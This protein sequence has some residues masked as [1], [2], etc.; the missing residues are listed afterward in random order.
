MSG[1]ADSDA[2]EGMELARLVGMTSD[3]LPT[4]STG[5]GPTAP[6]VSDA[7]RQRIRRKKAVD[8]AR[9]SVRFEGFIWPEEAEVLFARYV[10]GELDSEELTTT[11]L[12]RFKGSD[13]AD[14]DEGVLTGNRIREIAEFW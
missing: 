11:I 13:T 14:C 12:D 8:F 7:D 10:D 5:N 3:P 6:P 4:S 9:G 2:F 1:L